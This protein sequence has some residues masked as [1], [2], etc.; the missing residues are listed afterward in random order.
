MGRSGGYSSSRNIDDLVMM[1][2][3][4]VEDIDAE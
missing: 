2:E 4:I 3:M 1:V